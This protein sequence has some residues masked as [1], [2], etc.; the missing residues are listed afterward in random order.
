[1]RIAPEEN[2]LHISPIFKWYTKD[3]GG[4]DGIIDFLLSHLLEGEEFIWLSKERD[5]ISLR[6]KP[7]DWSLNGKTLN[8]GILLIWHRTN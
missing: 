3:F 5:R 2:A 8:R 7:Y 1:M 6:Y 4:R